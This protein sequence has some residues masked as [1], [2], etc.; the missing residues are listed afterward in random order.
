MTLHFELVPI[1]HPDAAALVAAVQ[2]EYVVRYGG[3][4]QTPLA[5]DAFVPPGGAF[6]VGYLDGEAVACGA[7]RLRS[8]VEYAGSRRAAEVKRMYVVPAARRRGL[9]REVLHHLARTAAEAG[10]EIV[11]LETGSKQPEAI[12]LYQSEGFIEIPG[13][14]H[15][16]C[17][18]ESVCY[19]R[20]LPL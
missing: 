1:D 12:A 14:G 5:E 8:D 13:F 18:P 2:Q 20:T 15:Y 6:F 19:A 10:A 4:D 7:W 9:A 3:V 17:A 11:V 16:R